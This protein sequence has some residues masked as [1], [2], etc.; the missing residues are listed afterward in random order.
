MM[1]SLMGSAK[2]PA[3]YLMIAGIIM[4][5]SIA[6]SKEAQNVVKTSVDLSRQDE[7]E[8]MFG[9]SRAARSIVRAAQDI[10]ESVAGVIPQKTQNWIESRFNKDDAIIADGASFDMIRAAVNLV[11]SSILIIIGT[12]YKMPLSTTYVT[13]M[14]AMGASLADHAWSRESA[15]FRV[16]QELYL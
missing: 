11:L 15:V 2:T 16:R 4:I 14:V 6:T 9:S 3:P 13:F 8:E 12:N 1:T 5:I 7:G 10:G